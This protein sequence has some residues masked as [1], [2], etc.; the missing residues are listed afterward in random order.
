[1]CE[2]FKLVLIGFYQ[3][4]FAR[5]CFV[6]VNRALY[7][8]S[9]RGLGVMNFENLKVSG[10]QYLLSKI[11]PSVVGDGACVV[12]DAGAHRGDY[13]RAVLQTNLKAQVF[14]F[15]PNPK[16]FARLTNIDD[17]RLQVYNLALGEQEDEVTLYDG[18]EDDGS[19]HATL[20][21]DVAE[22][23]HGSRL[24]THKVRQVRL[25]RMLE[26]LSITHVHLLKVDTEGTELVVIRGCGRFVET[27]QIDL[28][29]FEFNTMQV[30]SRCFL[31]DFRMA[32]PGYRFFRLLRDG[33][34]ELEPY[35][36]M[37][38]EIFAFQNVL[39]VRNTLV[40]R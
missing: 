27:A 16:S 5:R 7:N 10:E 40:L 30:Y 36:P 9:L 39:A 2:G 24:A 21:Q 35:D 32:L 14:A 20:L 23:E 33:L 28:I 11:L 18:A 38:S 34:V 13:S 29:Q 37:H 22:A 3:R 17:K 6:S 25:D 26:S 15:E 12:V 4:F 31:R 1:M 19:S 8:F